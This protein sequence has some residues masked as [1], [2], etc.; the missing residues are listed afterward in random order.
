MCISTQRVLADRRIY[1][2][3]LDALVEPT[4]KFTAGN[5]FDAATRMGPMIRER[6]AARVESWIR[7]AVDSG[8]RVVVGGE[9]QGT[10]HQ[11]TVVA[12]VK[13]NMRVFRGELFGPAVTVSA[14]NDINEAIASFRNAWSARTENGSPNASFGASLGGNDPILGHPVAYL[15]SFTYSRTQDVRVDQVRANALP[16]ESGGT[17][18]IDRYEGTTGNVGVLWGG[19]L[20][21]SSL[22]GTGNRLVLNATY[23]RTA[24]NEARAESGFSE[25]LAL[26]LDITRL[27]FVE[28]SVYSSQLKGEHEIGSN[29]R[30][31][32]S[33]TAS[34]V[35]RNEPATF[36]LNGVIPCWTEGV[37]LMKVGGKSRLVCPASL[38]YGDRGA[39]PRIRPGATLVFEVELLEIVK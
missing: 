38:A 14:F 11:P 23:N 8:A 29:H 16:V 26:P 5:P 1:S 37:Q 15:G 31:D 22:V 17:A 7:E 35:Q 13:P 6:D 32:W 18:E 19:L 21:L 24:D 28:R 2:D 12:D 4:R 39:P 3:L 30:I 9:R 10:L 36:P 20:Q 27:R 33:A 25:N 34:A